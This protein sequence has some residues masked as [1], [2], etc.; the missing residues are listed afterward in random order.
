MPVA[1]Y[2]ASEEASQDAAIILDLASVGITTN[3]IAEIAAQ[4]EAKGWSIARTLEQAWLFYRE[5]GGM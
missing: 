3:T 2:C 4:A 1:V 5:A